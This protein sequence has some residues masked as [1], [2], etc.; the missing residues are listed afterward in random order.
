MEW[1]GPVS[2]SSILNKLAP[3]LIAMAMLR[4]ISTATNF[5]II[6]QM[7]GNIFDNIA[8][9]IFSSLLFWATNITKQEV[10]LF[11][12]YGTHIY[13]TW[14]AY[15]IS[16]ESKEKFA[17]SGFISNFARFY[18]ALALL[19]LYT[20]IAYWEQ[21]VIFKTADTAALPLYEKTTSIIL[22][23]AYLLSIG[24]LFYICYFKKSYFFIITAVT[25]ALAATIFIFSIDILLIWMFVGLPNDPFSGLASGGSP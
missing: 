4:G 14:R 11:S 1:V 7:V 9:I 19:Y 20:H 24:V 10:I 8:Y 18:F 23:S 15:Q 21:A 25:I 12:I 17:W 16:L 3:A 6:S 13:T 22:L 2:F 5:T